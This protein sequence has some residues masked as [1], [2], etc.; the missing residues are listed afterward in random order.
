M[1]LSMEGLR[2]LVILIA[3]ITVVII[4]A[5][6]LITCDTT[7]TKQYRDRMNNRFQGVL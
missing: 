4:T 2:N 3:A 7:S 6:W 1:K 5:T